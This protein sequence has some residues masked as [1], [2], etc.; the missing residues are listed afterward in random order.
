MNLI[1]V[2]KLGT[3]LSSMIPNQQ[4]TRTDADSKATCPA[5][6]AAPV[7]TLWTCV[8]QPVSPKADTEADMLLRLP[9][10]HVQP[11]CL[12][13]R[14]IIITCYNCSKNDNLAKAS[15]GLNENTGVFFCTISIFSGQLIYHHDVTKK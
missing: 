8:S 3:K 2:K 13:I 11:P 10:P 9:P 7:K 12:C 4:C 5:I 6:Q 1:I 14:K 15:Y